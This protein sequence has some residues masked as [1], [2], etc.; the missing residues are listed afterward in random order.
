MRVELSDIRQT[1]T[2]I[3]LKNPVHVYGKHSILELT[4]CI[5]FTLNG[6]KLKGK[7][8]YVLP[9]GLTDFPILP[10]PAQ[11]NVFCDN[12]RDFRA[13]IGSF[14]SSM[15]TQ[16]NE[17]IIYAMRQRAR[18]DNL[19]I[20]YRQINKLTS[21]FYGSVLLLIMNFVITLSK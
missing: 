4:I 5:F 6:I 12:C 19:T 13:P 7:S 11:Q 9:C 15:C 18:A 16:T 2:T 21:V 17:V 20:R 10:K 8:Q 1:F 3:S 14:I